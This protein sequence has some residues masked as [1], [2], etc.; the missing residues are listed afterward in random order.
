MEIV[1]LGHSSFKLRG[2]TATL[3]TDPFDSE[4]VGIKFPKVE[5]DI[6]TVSHQ[7]EDH[8]YVAGVT[9]TPIVVAGPGEYEI[10]G[11]KIIGVGTYHDD[12]FGSKRGR[13]TIYHIEMDGLSLVHTGDLGHKLDEKEMELL[14]GVDILMVAIGGVYTIGPEEATGLIS[15]LEP[16]IIIPMHYKDPRGREDF[17]S[18]LA[19][20]EDF[21]K[22]MGKGS[23]SSVPKLNITKDKLPAEPTIVV[24]E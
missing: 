13:N 3:V 15:K 24:L 19:S 17:Y 22:Q 9:G 6:V 18:Q 11:V 21:L 20:V 7:H 1:R 10:K 8:N 2:K 14:D 4:M 12:T 23:I 16:E 5:A